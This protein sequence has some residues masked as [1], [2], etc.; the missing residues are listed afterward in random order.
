MFSAILA[1]CVLVFAFFLLPE[2]NV[3]KLI[4]FLLVGIPLLKAVVFKLIV[5]LT[6]VFLALTLTTH[7]G[8]PLILGLCSTFYLSITVV[9][10]GS[11]FY[12]F[13][14]PKDSG[15]CNKNLIRT[16]TYIRLFC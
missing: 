1:R 2:M 14:R 5:A 13:Q 3:L 9:I 7:C 15:F 12:A 10:A 8:V 11:V 16:A 6:S 4:I